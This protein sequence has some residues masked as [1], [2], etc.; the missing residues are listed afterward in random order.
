MITLLYPVINFIIFCLGLTYLL[1]DRLSTYYQQRSKSLSMS[2]FSQIGLE[3]QILQELN[4]AKIKH[5]NI[6]KM[7]KKMEI[8]SAKE[9]D[10]HQN[11]LR[12]DFAQQFITRKQEL[13]KMIISDQK[14]LFLDFYQEY[15]DEIFAE[16]KAEIIKDGS[17]QQQISQ[18]L[19]NQMVS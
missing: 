5:E 15:V 10:F 1:K 13:D 9:L 3:Q 12:E 6:E 18:T 7:Q 2:Y 8:L 17:Q 14:I 16:A 19:A 11:K 4:E